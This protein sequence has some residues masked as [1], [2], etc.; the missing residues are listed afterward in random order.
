MLSGYSP[1]DGSAFMSQRQEPETASSIVLACCSL[2][3]LMRMRYPSLQNETLDQE[4]IN[5]DVVPEAWRENA[6]LTDMNNAVGCNRATELAK[7]QRLSSGSGRGTRFIFA[8]FAIFIF[9]LITFNNSLMY[10]RS[11]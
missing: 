7:V 3:N 1:T 4:D 6:N 11:T 5:H 10:V 2:H 8:I 9:H